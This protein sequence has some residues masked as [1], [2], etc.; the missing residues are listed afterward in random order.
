MEKCNSG[1]R[2][3]WVSTKRSAS[4]YTQRDWVQIPSHHFRTNTEKGR[5]A[6]TCNHC[7]GGKEGSPGLAASIFPFYIHAWGTPMCMHSHMHGYIYKQVCAQVCAH[8]GEGTIRNQTQG[9]L[10]WAVSTVTFQGWNYRQ[11]TMLIWHLYGFVPVF[12]LAGKCLS[13]RASAAT[14]YFRGIIHLLLALKSQSSQ[15]RFWN[16][17]LFSLNW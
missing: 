9:S 5:A 3:E 16:S 12:L 7:W 1:W 11:A 13:C 4:P 10:I 2:T 6:H 8:A 15:W 14:V 17:Q